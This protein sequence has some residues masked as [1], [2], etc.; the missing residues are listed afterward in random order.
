V[1]W[2]LKNK[3]YGLIT[4]TIQDYYGNNKLSDIDLLVNNLL[5]HIDKLEN[6]ITRIQKTRFYKIRRKVLGIKN[7]IL[8]K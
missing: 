5:D 3:N 7:S 6:Y 4:Q 8:K 2:V 1:Q